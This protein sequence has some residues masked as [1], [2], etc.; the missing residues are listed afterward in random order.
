MTILSYC[1]ILFYHYYFLRYAC[2]GGNAGWT[3]LGFL[4][5]AF[6]IILIYVV[7]GSYYNYK[8]SEL[9]GWEMLPHREF[10]TNTWEKL[11]E[12]FNMTYEF[13]YGLYAK[14]FNVDLL[15]KKNSEFV[16]KK[17]SFGEGQKNYGTTETF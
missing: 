17:V 15:E 14:Y 1:V 9:R 6:F 10:W 2:A 16:T 4:I 12:G 5:A 3:F 13:C 7:G 11:R 8:N